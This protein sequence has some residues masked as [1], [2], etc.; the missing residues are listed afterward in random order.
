MVLRMRRARSFAEFTLS[1]RSEVLR[2][3][4]NDC[5]EGT[6]DCG[7]ARYRLSDRLQGGSFAAAV[8][9]ASRIFIQG[10]EAQGS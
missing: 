10:G 6:L 7:S 9:G 1:G 4:E 3:P 5:A 8:Q 2:C